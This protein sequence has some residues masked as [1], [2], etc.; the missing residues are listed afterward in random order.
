M[1][2]RRPAVTAAAG[3]DGI[4]DGARADLSQLA[5][6]GVLNLAGAVANGLL[7]FALTVVITRGL[8]GTRSR[9]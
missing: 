7:S 2:D 8:P 5:R 4:Q 3:F 1:T 9:P 6:G